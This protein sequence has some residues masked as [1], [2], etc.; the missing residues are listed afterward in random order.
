MSRRG[1]ELTEAHSLL[2]GELYE[3]TAGERR[4]VVREAELRTWRRSA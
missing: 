1:H 4:R 2:Y 3:R